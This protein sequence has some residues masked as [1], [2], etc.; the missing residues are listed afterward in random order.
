M[1]YNCTEINH[2]ILVFTISLYADS[3]QYAIKDF[4]YVQL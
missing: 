1:D 2:K 4:M 3:Y